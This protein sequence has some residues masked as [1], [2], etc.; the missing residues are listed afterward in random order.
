MRIYQKV[1]I[2]AVL[3]ILLPLL[4]SQA[5]T[6]GGQGD[7][8]AKKFDLVGLDSSVYS[9]ALKGLNSIQDS[10]HQKF[11]YLAIID[12]S[13]PS[14]EQRFYLIDLTDTSLVC[15]EH[16]C[17]GKY[18]GENFATSFSNETNSYKSSL[19]FYKLSETYY[20]EHGLSIR[21][22]GLDCGFN[23]NARKRA[24]V[25]H[26]AAY[27]DTSVITELG[28]LGRSLGCPTLPENTF[29]KIATQLS[30]SAIIF[31]YYPDANYLNNSVWLH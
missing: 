13:K 8:S 31:H 6:T 19:G 16:V 24:I 5:T 23:D 1:L 25:M 7:E 12:F 15:T 28:R 9:Y 26:T 10:L 14:T 11:R 17:H 20:G 27:A 18:S 22:D 4:S 2:V 21:M 3:A 30:N 29:N